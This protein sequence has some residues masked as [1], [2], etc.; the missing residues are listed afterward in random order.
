MTGDSND[1]VLGV[2]QSFSEKTEMIE[3]PQTRWTPAMRRT[4][5]VDSQQ[6]THVC[7]K[8]AQVKPTITMTISG[9]AYHAREI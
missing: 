3:R 4:E 7:K 8:V 1:R 5:T 6:Q 9:I 2:D